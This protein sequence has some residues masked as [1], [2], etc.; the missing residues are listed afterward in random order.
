MSRH[1][2]N[3]YDIKVPPMRES[4]EFCITLQ[5]YNLEQTCKQLREI[6]KLNT[7]FPVYIRGNDFFFF[8]KIQS[9]LKCYLFKPWNFFLFPY[10]YSSTLFFLINELPNQKM[11]KSCKSHS[12]I[13]ISPGGQRHGAVG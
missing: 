3:K 13:K 4:L 9:T 7:I 5:N 12:S 10:L 11:D 6:Y 2:G 1:K 8:F